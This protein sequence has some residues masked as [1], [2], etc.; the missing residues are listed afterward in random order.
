[1]SHVLFL[2]S[3]TFGI[4]A[5][6]GRRVAYAAFVVVG[7]LYF[8]A[9]VGFHLSPRACQVTL[10]VPLAFYSL[11]NY[12]HII[13]FTIFTVMTTRQFRT[14]TRSTV[15]LAGLMALVMGALVEAAEGITGSGNCRLRDLIPDS[16]GAV[17]GVVS[18]F[19]WA[20]IRGIVPSRRER[21]VSGHA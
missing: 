18:V 4:A 7:L 14:T 1:M 19:C 6:C 21:P 9:R 8:P 12:P 16:A 15:L 10:D 5:M 13:L 2:A 11:T 3:I 17:I 20:R